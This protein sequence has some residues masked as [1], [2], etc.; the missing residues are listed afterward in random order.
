M[1]FVNMLLSS[2]LTDDTAT[3]TV[4]LPDQPI[5]CLL[6]GEEPRSHSFFV[7]V[8]YL[9]SLT[10]V[11]R[12]TSV[13]KS[14]RPSLYWEAVVSYWQTQTPA[15]NL[16]TS[17]LKPTFNPFNVSLYLLNIKLNRF[18]GL[19]TKPGAGVA[20]SS[21]AAAAETL[22]TLWF[23]S[24]LMFLLPLMCFSFPFSYLLFKLLVFQFNFSHFFFHFF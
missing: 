13:I 11:F 15:L 10:G 23:F 17:T 18:N 21:Q 12:A 9:S 19:K 14:Q 7:S 3:V 5:V 16:Q 8:S 6:P 24:F 4:Q 1:N 20:L 22:S 2:C